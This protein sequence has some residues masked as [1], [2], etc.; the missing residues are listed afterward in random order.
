[1]FYSKIFGMMN[2]EVLEYSG[3]TL[4]LKIRDYLLDDLKKEKLVD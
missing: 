2:N 3:F 1:M 4:C